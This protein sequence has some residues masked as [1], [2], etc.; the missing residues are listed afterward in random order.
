MGKKVQ[1]TTTLTKDIQNLITNS[2]E[3]AIKA[4]NT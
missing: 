4:V 1:T 3:T 2:Q